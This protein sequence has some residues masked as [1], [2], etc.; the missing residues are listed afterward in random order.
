LLLSE[1]INSR[2]DEIAAKQDRLYKS[3]L[4]VEEMVENI[5]DRM[6]VLQETISVTLRAQLLIAE[7]LE[8]RGDAIEVDGD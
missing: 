5:N 7:R 8:A 3:S 1:W 4:P 6:A 2:I